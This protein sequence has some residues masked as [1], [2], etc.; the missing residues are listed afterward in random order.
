M[1]Y[2]KIVK[3]C[4]NIANLGLVYHNAIDFATLFLKNV[5]QKDI[6]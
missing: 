2:L 5:K 1:D 3:E 4:K 6:I